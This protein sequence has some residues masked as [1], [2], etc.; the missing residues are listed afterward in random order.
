MPQVSKDNAGNEIE[1]TAER[2]TGCVTGDAESSAELGA[3]LGLVDADLASVVEAW[4][5]LPAAIKAGIV[6]M[7][8]AAGR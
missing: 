2:V 5:T 8:K 4:D 6:A 1:G 7:V 3:G